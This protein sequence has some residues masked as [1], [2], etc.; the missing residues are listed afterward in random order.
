[1][2]MMRRD[3]RVVGSIPLGIMRRDRIRPQRELISRGVRTRA[4]GG[5]G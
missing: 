4:R 1:M 3:L 2:G 5:A